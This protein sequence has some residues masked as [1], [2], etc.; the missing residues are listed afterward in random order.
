MCKKS[1]ICTY[2]M[3]FWLFIIFAPGFL[4][5]EN[6]FEGKKIIDVE[7]QGLVKSEVFSV[8]SI[9]ETKARSNFSQ[10][11]I[12]IDIKSLY[13]LELFDDIKV[14]VIEHDEGLVVTFIFVELPTIREIIIKGNKK[15]SNRTIKDK[16]LLKKGSVYN[17]QEVYNDV[18][19]I[20]NLY[21][22]K[23]FPDTAVTYKI[24]ETKEKDKKTREK[25]DSVDL[26]FS[27]KE[28][29]KLIIRTLN[30]SGVESVQ[31]EKLRY[32]MKT[33]ERGYIFSQ[34]FFKDG[35]FELDKREILRYYGI[36][37]FIDAEIIKVDKTIQRNERKK[38]NEMD[39]TIYIEEGNQYTF[40]GVKISG[41]KIFTDDE[42]YSLI[43][44][45][46]NT[47]F[48]K[49][50]WETSVQSIRNLFAT[51][52]YIYYVM[53]IQENKDREKHVVSYS[54]QITEN[55]KA[56]IEHIFITGNEKTEKFVI[57]RELEILE[58][59]IFNARKIQRSTEKLYNLQYF[60]TVNLD[61][62]PG[63]ELGL[64]D[65][66]FDV[67]EQRTGLFSFGL[68]A[69]TAGQGVS[70]FEEVSANNFLGRGLK[71][72]EK[73]D[74]GFTRQS[75]GDRM[76][77]EFGIDE[78]WLFN[79]PTSVGLTL[80]AS[81]IVYGEATGDVIYVDNDEDDIKDGDLENPDTLEYL[82]QDIKVALRFGRRFWYYYGINSELAF[83]VFRNY[84]DDRAFE[85]L[86]M[87]QYD[88]GWPVYWKNYLSV[89]GYRD[90]RDLSIF[91]TRG[92]FVSQ[93]ITFFGGPLGGY[94]DFLKLNTDINVNV[95]TF[96][97]FVL[98]T[99]LN[100]GFIFPWL[101]LPLKI[102][103]ADYIRVDGMNEGR[104]W[105]RPSYQFESLYSLKGRSELNISIEHRFPIE[106]R[107]VW[108]ITFFD[109]SGLYDTPGDFT[110]DPKELYY[111][112]GLGVSFLIPGF[113]IRLYLARRFKYDDD[114]E[115]WQFANSQTFFRDWDFIFAVAGFF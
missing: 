115:K 82:H 5:A 56:H 101:G 70:L 13:N 78:P 72:Y 65:L 21:E 34:G 46:E 43:K 112:I 26:I 32:K 69:S 4:L 52:G 17:E 110:I 95:H 8:K 39:L 38:R 14:D 20:I 54:I 62:K 58:G 47:V 12:D 76:S 97:K 81:R 64:V 22:E 89:T 16:I 19:E 42:L 86:L 28:S 88:L 48:N 67:E 25:I 2:L 79:T 24:K 96:W 111:S 45:K 105:Q 114:I 74:I 15:V 98:S 6:S 93:N 49:I 77:I 7:F 11:T 57:E 44:I 3:F 80:S 60:S 23:G 59:E 87:E 92:T 63:S 103:D 73:V 109:I 104:G 68:S 10:K 27:I 90:T 53:D 35:Q 108:G 40:G 107:I 66:I 106:E 51:N 37:G 99:R 94:S 36:N 91:A 61:V 102:D 85:G 30:F 100:F 84:S 9:I 29:K 71:L 113:P 55:S 75:F 1:L 41:N 50:T 33:R 31:E 18:K 83:S